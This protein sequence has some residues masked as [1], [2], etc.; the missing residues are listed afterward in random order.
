MFDMLFFII[1]TSLFDSVS[2]TQQIII[3]A[4]LLAT[5]RPAANA[6]SFLAG[7]SLSYLALGIIGLLEI[8]KLNALL[9]NFINM[10]SMISDTSYYKIQLI[11]G[12]L[13][14]IWGIVYAVRKKYSKKPPSENSLIARLKRINPVICLLIGVFITVSCFPVSLPYIGAIEKLDHS[15]LAFHS[16]ILM[17]VLY[18]I[19]YALPMLIV[20]PLY[21][22][23]RS[24]VEDWEHKLH[25]HINRWNVV[26]TFLLLA[27][28]G[29]LFII[30]SAFYYSTAHPLL[31][32]KF[33]W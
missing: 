29:L 13:F 31:K 7:L 25:F 30:D 1:T 17:I 33:L 6:F 18:N 23:L 8:G 11:T 24:H 12:V 27:G 21:L 32:T 5:N 15:S 26:L 2:T 22:Y 9:G 10:P 20:Y 14:L 16:R 28:M 3:F 19:V 4:L